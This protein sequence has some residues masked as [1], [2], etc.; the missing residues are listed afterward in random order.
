M[1]DQEFKDSCIKEV[2]E[3]IKKNKYPCTIVRVSD[4]AQTRCEWCERT[5]RTVYISVRATGSREFTKGHNNNGQY[6]IHEDTN[7]GSQCEWFVCGQCPD[8]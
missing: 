4:V 1:T 6:S 3:D 8:S 2:E 7:F 5:T